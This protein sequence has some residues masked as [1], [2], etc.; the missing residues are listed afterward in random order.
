MVEKAD[1]KSKYSSDV[2]EVILTE[3]SEPKLKIKD[4]YKN[5]IHIKRN[6]F[7]IITNLTIILFAGFIDLISIGMIGPLIGL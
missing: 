2:K 3:N 5:L 1:V 7:Q 4:Y 6:E